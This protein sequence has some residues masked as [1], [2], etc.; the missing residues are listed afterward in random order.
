[1]SKLKEIVFSEPLSPY[2]WL[3]PL[4]KHPVKWKDEDYKTAFHLYLCL[5]FAEGSPIRTLIKNSDYLLGAA[6]I[7]NTH[8]KDAVVKPQTDVDVSNMKICIDLKLKYN[9]SIYELLMK[10]GD[11]PIVFEPSNSESSNLFW[12]AIRSNGGWL[13][14]NKLGEIW[15]NAR[16]FLSN[17]N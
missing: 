1:M 14:Q 8:R 16:K 10:T 12:G 9:P 7:A 17:Q 6:I 4:Y 13:G 2:G 15:V 11:L 3:S 5:R